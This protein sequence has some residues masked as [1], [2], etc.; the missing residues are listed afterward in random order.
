MSAANIHPQS[1]FALAPHHDTS[2]R[3]SAAPFSLT[4]ILP[5]VDA[6][7]FDEQDVSRTSAEPDP[8]IYA[9]DSGSGTILHRMGRKLSA[10]LPRPERSETLHSL[11]IPMQTEI[12][13]V[14]ESKSEDSQDTAMHSWRK[15]SA[16]GQSHQTKANNIYGTSILGI[17]WFHIELFIGGGPSMSFASTSS[18]LGRRR[19]TRKPAP[20][21]V[22]DSSDGINTCIEQV[23]PNGEPCEAN[24]YSS[25]T[26]RS[27]S[28]S[29]PSTS[30]EQSFPSSSP[31]QHYANGGATQNSITLLP[32]IP[33][34]SPKR[35]ATIAHQ[36]TTV[37]PPN[38]T[39]RIT[40]ARDHSLSTLIKALFGVNSNGRMQ[41]KAAVLVSRTSSLK[42]MNSKASIAVS[43]TK[44][45]FK[46][47]RTGPTAASHESNVP[48]ADQTTPRKFESL[49]G[50]ERKRMLKR[51]QR[52][53]SR[54]FLPITPLSSR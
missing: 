20:I 23:Y 29:V 32:P 26:M 16:V 35:L 13:V 2:R 17:L 6:S 54:S 51:R 53:G 11:R 43:P 41:S 40:N 44:M 42:R 45:K 18:S 22:P 27:R 36:A 52:E 24:K 33:P 7:I 50:L 12:Q 38:R 1:A 39:I 28:Y 30:S 49:F 25:H 31:L 3:Y 5:P 14:R 9:K 34:R 8:H 47:R 19:I 21:F 46:R 37:N 4:A 48:N 15:L 10:F